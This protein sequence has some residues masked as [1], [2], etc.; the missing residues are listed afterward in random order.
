VTG[1]GARAFRAV[2][3]ERLLETGSSLDQA[4]GTVGQGE[5]ANSDLYASAEYRK[6]L[7]RVRAK[8][9]LEVALRRAS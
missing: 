7:V 3:A 9:A 8:R 5:D 2:E 4:V 1:M 6:H